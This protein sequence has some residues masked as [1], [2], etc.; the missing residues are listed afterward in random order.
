MYC[1]LTES[2]LTMLLQGSGKDA[3]L[4]TK[5]GILG[6]KDAFIQCKNRAKGSNNKKRMLDLKTE[7]VKGIIALLA[8]FDEDHKM[9]KF[10][11]YALNERKKPSLTVS[12]VD[13]PEASKEENKQTLDDAMDSLTAP[14]TFESSFG[15]VQEILKD[16]F[17]D[18][19]NSLKCLRIVLEDRLKEAAPNG[20]R[21]KFLPR[22]MNNERPFDGRNKYYDELNRGGNGNFGVTDDRILIRAN[23]SL[24]NQSKEWIMQF[25]SVHGDATGEKWLSVA[26]LTPPHVRDSFGKPQRL[27][28]SKTTN[29]HTNVT[30]CL[31][32]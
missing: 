30:F 16:V 4:S 32:T 23:N 24:P 10:R 22:A 13:I 26:H 11:T 19:K 15:N 28:H 3:V 18:K 14:S 7:R 12:D 21:R 9:K 17:R 29:T 25:L 31:L 27:I 6:I 5:P 1:C 20:A 2:L 8:Q